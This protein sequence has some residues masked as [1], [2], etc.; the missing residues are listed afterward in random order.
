MPF[1]GARLLIAGGEL[2]LSV[3][4]GVIVW[5]VALTHAA[6]ATAE[7]RVELELRLIT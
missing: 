7:S 1:A 2:R 6:L 5:V 4:D 3:M